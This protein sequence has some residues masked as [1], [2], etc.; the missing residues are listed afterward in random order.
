MIKLT[1]EQLEIIEVIGYTPKLIED[2]EGKSVV[3]MLDFTSL[4]DAQR[5]KVS[6]ILNRNK[7]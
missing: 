1:E 6:I 7:E 3:V 5:E 4:T 2:K